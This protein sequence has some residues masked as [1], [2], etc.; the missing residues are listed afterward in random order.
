MN[1][2]KKLHRQKEIILQRNILHQV[3]GECTKEKEQCKQKKEG[4]KTGKKN[5][6]HMDTR[7]PQ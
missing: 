7:R 4:D 3:K 1:Y 2:Q 5:N 6:G